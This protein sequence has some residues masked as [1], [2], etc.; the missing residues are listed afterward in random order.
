MAAVGRKSHASNCQAFSRASLRHERRS[1]RVDQATRPAPPGAS[2]FS[3]GDGRGVHETV[4]ARATTGSRSPWIVIPA[5][6][7]NPRPGTR[8][9]PCLLDSC[10]TWSGLRPQPKCL[11]WRNGRTD[12]ESA[13]VRREFDA[14]E[15]PTVKGTATSAVMRQTCKRASRS[16]LRRRLQCEKLPSHGRFGCARHRWEWTVRFPYIGGNVRVLSEMLVRNAKMSRL[17]HAGTTG[18]GQRLAAR[19]EDPTAAAHARSSSWATRRIPQ[20]GRS[21]RTIVKIISISLLTTDYGCNTMQADYGC[22]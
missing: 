19:Q 15:P 7:Q 9:I 2:E 10:L 16:R 21:T 18:S 11:L 22:D 5:K 1:S 8:H 12:P 6:A 4:S 20:S 3:H 17:C 13:A 14:L